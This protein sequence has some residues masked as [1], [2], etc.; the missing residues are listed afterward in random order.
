MRVCY[1]PDVSPDCFPNQFYAVKVHIFSTFPSISAV[2]ALNLTLV[3]EINTD[4]PSVA[5][6]LLFYN[7]TDTDLTTRIT[8]FY[9]GT[10]STVNYFTDFPK[11]AKLL[12]DRLYTIY[13]QD[14]AIMQSQYSEVRLY[15]ND[16]RFVPGNNQGSFCSVCEHLCQHKQFFMHSY[17]QCSGV[18]HEAELP[19][20]FP[21]FP[22]I[23]PLSGN[24]EMS[25]NLV[26]T[27][28]QFASGR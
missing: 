4:W 27:W 13:T 3:N 15:F 7:A 14:T 10:N 8:Q 20:L 9:F 11:I 22:Y 12:S 16:Y 2:I 18:S 17:A 26:K 21:L 5:P 25:R 23:G 24:Y 1:S 19:L 28:V 6:R